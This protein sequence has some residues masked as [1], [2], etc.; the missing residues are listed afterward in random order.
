M[1]TRAIVESVTFQIGPNRWV[2]CL[3]SQEEEFK[4]SFLQAGIRVYRIDA[5]NVE[6]AM[7][8]SVRTLSWERTQ[9]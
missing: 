9:Q 3:K 4:N 2:T 6:N 7:D 1:D 5:K 8:N